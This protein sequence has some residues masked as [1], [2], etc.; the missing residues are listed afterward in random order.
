MISSPVVC[1]TLIGRREE[2]NFLVAQLRRATL[3]SRVIVPISGPAGIGKT[4]LLKELRASAGGS[5]ATFVTGNCREH[6]QAPY[7]AFTTV[8]ESLFGA[9]WR[10]PAAEGTSANDR[11]RRLSAIA[12]AFNAASRKRPIV[13]ALED[14]HWADDATL[15]LIEYIASDDR[16]AS[17]LL[18]VTF[19]DDA[20]NMTPRLTAML[21]NLSRRECSRIE[22]RGLGR[23]ATLDLMRNALH[24]RANFS[25][26]FLSEI[27]EV[28]EGN[29]LFIE[30]CLR[31]IVDHGA[32][33]IVAQRDLPLTMRAMLAERL[34]NVS[35]E[36]RDVLVRA[37]VIGRS[38]DIGLLQRLCGRSR[39]FVIATLQRAH[40]LQLV[41]IGRG[42]RPT[43]EFR[44]ALVREALR[45]ELVPELA[46]AFHASI[47]A[48]LSAGETG[49]TTDVEL[50][51]HWECAGDAARA[52]TAYERAGD[53]AS[54][55]CAFGDAARLYR[56]AANAA[57]RWDESGQ[58]LYEKL[59]GA[60]ALSGTGETPIP[61]FVAACDEY[62]RRDDLERLA[63]CSL[64]YAR[65]CSQ[66]FRNEETVEAVGRI[67]QLL[68]TDPRNVV[69]WHADI[70]L[71]RHFA[72]LGDYSR[73]LAQLH[74]AEERGCVLDAA[75][76]S[77]LHETKA[78]TYTDMGREADFVREGEAA[79]AIATA[80]QLPEMTVQSFQMLGY[81]LLLYGRL[82]E[83][84]ALFGQGEAL[85]TAH[86]YLWRAAL[87]R[88]SS[89]KCHFLLGNLNEA[90][91][92]IVESLDA[93]FEFSKVR[94]LVSAVGVQVGIAMADDWL[95][96]ATA[97]ESII[98]E[99]L[100]TMD[101]VGIGNVA[102]AYCDYYAARGKD[103]RAGVLIDRA[104]AQVATAY[105]T[106]E[107]LLRFG[108]Y[109]SQSR[110]SYA[111]TLFE[112]FLASAP[113]HAIAAFRDLFEA[114]VAVRAGDRVAAAHWA[115]TA[116]ERFRRL[117]HPLYAAQ[118]VEISHGPAEALTIY[119]EFGASADIAR[120]TQ[121]A[122]PARRAAPIDMLTERQREVV[123]LICTGKTNRE[124][125]AL[126]YIKPKTV[127]HHLENIFDRLGI[128]SRTQLVAQ[129]IAA[130]GTSAIA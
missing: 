34:R 112:R 87:A 70:V 54:E 120:L 38:F 14:V 64:R 81:N 33:D 80:A 77:V 61:W 23:A 76:N 18:L 126:L 109:G 95:I 31:S 65:Q 113:D 118:A 55:M 20:P 99:A 92:L 13:V 42:E 4:R 74:A 17:I 102:A 26:G 46:A 57:Y 24:G 116:A 121:R 52:S 36:E 22:L 115:R 130:E 78:L 79:L 6:V 117:R 103:D 10:A 114:Y 16:P 66:E 71:A 128:N 88:L 11:G 30:E 49:E 125:A 59:A 15:D 9:G 37:A 40:D 60:L 27:A 123:A 44:H 106:A 1:K 8:Y 82:E 29:P 7:L 3:G 90:R 104:A 69:H 84:I 50:A 100:V 68:S 5:G 63:A 75:M 96:A 93:R 111:R 19:R 53:H 129:W 127:E 51:Y 43:Y 39:E 119:R 97:D 47:A 107:L 62:A 101:P 48:E 89:A 105:G 85:A 110:I 21:A 25:D 67:H 73:A 28:C 94:P 12:R 2:L 72:R 124:V 45:G 91:R 41:V 86:G 58:H 35:R 56:K 32:R 108:R 122:A 83:A 98:D